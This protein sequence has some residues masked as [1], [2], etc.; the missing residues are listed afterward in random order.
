LN[1]AGNSGGC[2][3]GGVGVAAAILAIFSLSST[4]D[5]TELGDGTPYI[6][7]GDHVLERIPR[8]KM[9]LPGYFKSGKLPQM[10]WE[11]PT[12]EMTA[13][14]EID[15]KTRLPID[16]NI[17]YISAPVDAPFIGLDHANIRGAQLTLPAHQ[18]TSVDPTIPERSFP[19]PKDGFKIIVLDVD[20]GKVLEPAK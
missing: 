5:A 10:L 18:A 6:K 17:L 8:S 19:I 9:S 15:P 11:K 2:F 20:S 14:V 16:P 13:F 1:A 4:A 3:G 12:N 7:L